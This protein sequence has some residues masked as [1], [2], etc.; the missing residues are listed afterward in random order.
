MLSHA[1][2]LLRS[3]CIAACVFTVL[4]QSCTTTGG[5]NHQPGN[6]SNVRASVQMSDNS[7][8]NGYI[9]LPTASANSA[10]FYH[11]VN[12]SHVSLDM[13]KVVSFTTDRGTY[14]RKTLHKQGNGSAYITMTAFVKRLTEPGAL[15]HVYEYEEL[16]SNNPK[17]SLKSVQKTYYATMPGYGDENVWDINSEKFTHNFN[18]TMQQV[19]SADTRM[20][21]QIQQ[22][23]KKYY[24]K[25]FS[26]RSNDKVR[27]LLNLNKDYNPGNNSNSHAA[28]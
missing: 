25:P 3:S 24:Y 1:A 8:Q 4:L 2:N 26:M 16:V 20:V 28:N 13:N 7:L 9:T 27:I 17:S 23:N 15:I 22:M 10:S 12:R 18:Q 6:I 21:E 19:Y 5:L 11:P 14:E